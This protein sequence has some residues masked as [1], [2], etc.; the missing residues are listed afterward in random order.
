MTDNEIIEALRFCSDPDTCS[1]DCSFYV[2]GETVH[3]CTTKLSVAAL[4][5]IQRQQEEIEVL[6]KKA[7]VYDSYPMKVLV[8]HNSEV[9]SKTWED[10]IDFISDVAAEGVKEF[11]DKVVKQL[12]ELEKEQLKIYKEYLNGEDYRIATIL[13]KALDIVKGVQNE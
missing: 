7:D 11:A 8:G 2:E 12:E 1:D 3:E 9:F 13:N 4:D 10:Y 6:K 5:L